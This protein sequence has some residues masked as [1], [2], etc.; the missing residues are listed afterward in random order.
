MNIIYL[1]SI[2]SGYT[3][4]KDKHDPFLIQ[5]RTRLFQYFLKN[6]STHPTLR[7][8]HYFHRFIDQS[9]PGSLWSEGITTIPARLLE[10]IDPSSNLEN[11]TV[12]RGKIPDPLINK[13]EEMTR[14]YREGI[15]SI[16][17]GQSKL[18]RKFKGNNRGS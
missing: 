5:H 16:E 2:I 3:G 18:I 7:A 1:A 14:K 6:I 10:G 4:L 12:K 8:D 9:L 13:F 15:R 11:N 17:K